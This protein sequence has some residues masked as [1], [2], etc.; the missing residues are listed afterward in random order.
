MPKLEE[1]SKL[2]TKIHW[3]LGI[4]RNQGHTHARA[5]R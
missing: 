1:R 5:L 2:E 4:W 3:G